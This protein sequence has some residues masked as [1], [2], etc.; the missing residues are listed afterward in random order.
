MQTTYAT[1]SFSLHTMAFLAPPLLW[2]TEFGFYIIKNFFF[3]NKLDLVKILW[4]QISAAGILYFAA[5]FFGYVKFGENVSET[6]TLDLPHTLLEK[7]LFLKFLNIE[8]LKRIFLR[9]YDIVRG[10]FA[11]AVYFSAAIVFFPP[12]E[13][14]WRENWFNHILIFK[15]E[16]R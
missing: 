4:V 7:Y 13:R 6:V 10:L 12:I 14:V 11:I 3:W 9:F 5:A 2:L 8:Y 1:R 15:F 16:N